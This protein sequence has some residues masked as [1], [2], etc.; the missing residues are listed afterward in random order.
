MP[1]PPAPWR[2]LG[3]DWLYKVVWNWSKGE[4]SFYI[5]MLIIGGYPGKEL[6]AIVESHVR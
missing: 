3:L 1:A 5:P 2:S 6:E 4:Y